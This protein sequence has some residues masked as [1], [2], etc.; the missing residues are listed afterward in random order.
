MPEAAANPALDEEL[1]YVGQWWVP[2]FEHQ[3]LIGDL[4]RTEKRGMQLRFRVAEGFTS[5]VQ[6]PI[7]V[8][9]GTDK[10]GKPVTLFH[11]MWA[12]DSQSAALCNFAYRVG[13]CFH[14]LHLHSW[15]DAVFDEYET[16]LEHL[17]A[18]VDISGFLQENAPDLEF[19]IHHRLPADREFDSGKGFKVT[20]AAH[21]QAQSSIDGTRSIKE[22]WLLRLV[23]PEPQNFKR[24]RRDAHKIRRLLSLAVGKPLHEQT[25][26]LRRKIDSKWAAGKR[27]ARDIRCISS[28]THWPNPS[29]KRHACEMRFSFPNVE[30]EFEKILRCWMSLQ[31]RLADVL[32]LLFST[33]E[34]SA[35]YTHHK[36]LVLAQ[37][38]EVYHR[39]WRERYPQNVETKVDFTARKKR[40][41]S[42]LSKTDAAWLKSKIGAT[43]N[44]TLDTR[45]HAVLADKRKWLA[46]L[47][48]NEKEFAKTV[49]LLRNQY[50]HWP[51]PSKRKTKAKA[52]DTY[53][54]YERLFR[55]LLVCVLSDL[56]LPDA[57]IRR[58]AKYDPG[59]WVSYTE[60]EEQ[61]P[62]TNSFPLLG[63]PLSRG[64]NYGKPKKKSA[65]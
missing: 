24:I 63:L 15:A 16:D 30:Q 10:H 31:E 60:K 47:V 57:V 37:A 3:K 21:G 14:G 33:E 46:G 45:L 51:E 48:V 9:H 35:L 29:R 5:G 61:T 65:D 17:S 12:G 40:I 26:I 13:Y 11:S 54:V 62:T 32:N 25:F 2:G 44:V 1:I 27:L 64:R 59:V 18:W 6:Q 53:E 7:K 19:V 38:L 41:L 23:Y 20:L 39:C 56:G 42:G 52:A 58:A 55:V 8:I 43:N 4:V 28:G 34:N 50:T 36:F 49:R 22:S